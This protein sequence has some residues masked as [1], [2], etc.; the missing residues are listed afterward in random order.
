MANKYDVIVVGAGPAGITAAN[1]LARKGWETLIV[2]R[3]SQQ[4]LQLPETFY[5]I[6]RD[7]LAQL[8]IEQEIGMAIALPKPIRLISA[9]D[10]F[11]Y[12]I[13][14]EPNEG[15]SSHYGMN[16]NRAILEKVLIERAVGGGATYLPTTI[17]KDF[18]FADDQLT[19]IKCSTPD[20]ELEYTAKVVIE[21]RGQKTPLMH[22]LVTSK[23]KKNQ[24]NHIAVFAQ[25][26]KPSF[27]E[28]IPDNGIL[29]I[30]L[31]YGYILA[32]PLA[33][34]QIS[35]IVALEGKKARTNNR[36]WDKIFQ[37]TV[38][39]WKPL[40]KAIQVAE[41]L[42]PTL[43]VINHDWEYERFSGNVFLFVG[44]AVAFLDPFSCNGMAIGMNSGEIAADFVTQSLAKG[45]GY[46]GG[47]NLSY[48]QQ[49]RTLINNWK[50]VWGIENLSL[51][52]MGLLKQSLKL[53]GQL[54]LLKLEALNENW[55]QNSTAFASKT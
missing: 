51:S 5:G 15:T 3:G 41:K 16:L 11:I 17:V 13:G 50:Q 26:S 33:E 35:V 39:C 24:D 28:V 12:H 43:P 7:L 31:D 14:I 4:K 30:T 52:G 38:E 6:S 44:D 42:T 10:N 23:E 40:A 21:A 22:R 36:N 1:L 32:M 20:G 45:N 54:Q 47:E 53:L 25:F 55:K 8:D 37:E 2:D 49:I 46:W 29:A 27:T 18:I 34:Q 48:D 9:S 19:G